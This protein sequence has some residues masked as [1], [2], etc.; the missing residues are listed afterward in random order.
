M[1][2]FKV[3]R[4]SVTCVEE[5]VVPPTRLSDLLSPFDAK[6][7]DEKA[8]LLS[9]GDRLNEAGEFL[10][11]IQNWLVQIDDRNILIDT[12]FGN[13]K[14]RPGLPG[15]SGLHT[16]FLDNLASAG[17][18]PEDVELVLCTHLHIDHVGWNTRWDGER[19]IPTFPNARY[20]FT[21][22]DRQY[23]D[24]RNPSYAPSTAGRNMAQGVFEDSVQ[25]ILD[26][27]LAG[28]IASNAIIDDYFSV[29]P[30][31]GHSP[32]QVAIKLVSDGE[33]LL[34]SGDVLHHPAQVLFTHWNT[35]YCEDP[36]VAVETRRRILA[37]CAD[38]NLILAPAHFTNAACRIV[39]SDDGFLPQNISTESIADIGS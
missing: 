22:I 15:V 25:P 24:P 35:A 4:V 1:K 31:P 11:K 39:R 32:G 17:V 13:D 29:I 19:W 37:L 10:P 21:E 20:I 16:N 7:L 2:R 27:G 33:G 3:G 8:D 30:A 26:A 5:L 28:T 6:L 18:F 36:S 38:E 23:W 14:E 34:F 9:E 12:G